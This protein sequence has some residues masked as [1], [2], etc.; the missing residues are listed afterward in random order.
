[1]RSGLLMGVILMMAFLNML[2]VASILL[3]VAVLVNR[4]PAQTNAAL[5]TCRHSAYLGKTVK[6]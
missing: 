2:G 6:V 1:M 5:N 3:F 4:K